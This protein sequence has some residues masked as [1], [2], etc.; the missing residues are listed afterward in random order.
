MKSLLGKGAVKL[1]SR[2]DALDD[3]KR[4]LLELARKAPREVRRDLL[5]DDQAF[6]S[7]GLGYNQRLS[8]VIRQIWNPEQAASRSESLRRARSRLRQ[9][10]EATHALRTSRD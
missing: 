7:Q 4:S 9:M 6:A 2:P 3:P 10:A 8:A 1:P 5:A